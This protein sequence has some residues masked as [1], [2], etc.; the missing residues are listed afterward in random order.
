MHAARPTF[1]Q[2]AGRDI[3][4]FDGVCVLCSGFMRF[5]VRH[6]TTRR[7]HFVVAQSPLGEALYLHYGLTTRGDYD[8]NL[9]FRDGVLHER[10]DAFLAVMA[11][12][13]W[14]WRAIGVLHVLPATAKSW[15]YERIARNR[16]AVFGRRATC[17]VPD[18][19]LRARF[20]E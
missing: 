11:C 5:V 2:L 19:A 13:G 6:D 16:F 15:L 18:A 3:I 4:V 1:P 17:L 12:L 10:L 20:I 7:F 14:P 9:V 8:T